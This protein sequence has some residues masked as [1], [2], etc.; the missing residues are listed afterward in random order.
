M[1]RFLAIFISTV[2]IKNH[3]IVILVYSINNNTN[4]RRIPDYSID[5]YDLINY[6]NFQSYD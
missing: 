4:P 3:I 5:Y 2:K 1:S 6:L